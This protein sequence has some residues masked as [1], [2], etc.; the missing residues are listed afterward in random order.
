MADAKLPSITLRYNGLF[1]FDAMYAMIIDWA[2]NYGYMWHERTYKHKVP[3]PKGAEQEFVWQMT[4]DVTEYVHHD[5][6]F[7]V[8]MWDLTEVQVEIDGKPK[9]LSNARLYIVISGTLKS[10]WQ[11]KFKGSKLAEKLGQWFGKISEK[12]MDSYTDALYYRVWNLQALM[13][14]YF[15]MQSKKYQYKGYL[16]EN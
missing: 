7:S 14:K 15:D 2:K 3:S 9:S 16:G 1:D 10:D 4:K 8:H 11:G 13:K 6:M 5:I 12:E